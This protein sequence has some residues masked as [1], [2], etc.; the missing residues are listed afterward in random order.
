MICQETYAI[1]DD[2]RQTR[3]K[4]VIQ[5][6]ISSIINPRGAMTSTQKPHITD[7][8]GVVTYTTSLVPAPTVSA[9]NSDYREEITKITATLNKLEKDSV[10]AK[11]FNSISE[12][13]DVLV[14]LAAASPYKIA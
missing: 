6:L 5:S 4:A 2:Q 7:F 1:N 13:T 3:Y 10:H 8:K 9:I 12:L 14:D 11:S